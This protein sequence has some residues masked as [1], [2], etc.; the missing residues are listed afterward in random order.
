MNNVMIDIE[1]L[2]THPGSGILAIAAVRFNVITAEYD[3]DNVF[4]ASIG[5]ENNSHMDI[6][7]DTVAWWESQEAELYERMF[8]PSDPMRLDDALGAF[9]SFIK[10]NDR[11]WG[12]S[13]RFDLGI[14]EGAYRRHEM[15]IPWR[16][17]NERDVRTLVALDDSVKRLMDFKGDKHD[18]VDDCIHQIRYCS[19]IFNR[20]R[21]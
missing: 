1:T 3:A 6:V 17:Y 16:Y 19:E 5:Y 11:V 15:Q 9:S 21:R 13:A 20:L 12:N 8:R 2:G 4:S 18:P 7:Q 14:I 10:P